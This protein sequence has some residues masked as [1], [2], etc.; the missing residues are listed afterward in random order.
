MC[1]GLFLVQLDVTVVNVA[2]PTIGA[3][4]GTSVSGL[5]WVVDGYAVPFASLLLAGGTL[6]DRYG[7]RRLVLWGLAIFAVGSTACGFAPTAGV[8]IAARAVQG[9]GAAALLPATLAVITHAYP[10]KKERAKAIGIWAAVAGLSLPLGPLLGGLL[11]A[12]PGWRRVF[13]INLPIIAGALYPV[14]RAVPPSREATARRLD[15]PGTV[16]GALTLTCCTL[17]LIEGGR[18]GWLTAA[19]AVAFVATLALACAFLFTEQRHPE[20]AVP[21]SFFRDRG[22]STANGAALVVNLVGVSTVFNTT[23][24]LQDV[25]HLAPLP[26]GAGLLPMFVPLIGLAPLTGRITARYGPRLPATT[27]LLLGATGM[28]L[29]ITVEADT[30]YARL[31]PTLILLGTALGLLITPL[32]ATAVSTPPHDR[33]GLASAINNTARQTG[34]ALGIALFGSLTGPPTN[35]AT[36]TTGLHY[37]AGTAA[38]LYILTAA[39]TARWLPAHTEHP[40]QS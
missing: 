29:L 34:G 36:F 6:G 17:T 22:F 37:I 18:S 4:L 31:L 21:L 11:V 9:V 2:L 23:L 14:L 3:D 7:H 26:A 5:Q 10:E 16:L 38:A 40:G 39:A 15:I 24:Y 27:G 13:L 1:I 12:G 33:A 28:A 30:P 35:P 19:T 8:L 20:P 25:L 32:V